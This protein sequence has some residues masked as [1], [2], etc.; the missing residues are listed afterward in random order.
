MTDAELLIEILFSGL[1]EAWE[2]EDKEKA[3]A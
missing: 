2:N 1:V 3:A